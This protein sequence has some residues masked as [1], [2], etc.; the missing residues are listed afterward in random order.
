MVFYPRFFSIGRGCRQ[1]DP[2]SPY[3]FT[4]SVEIIAIMIR[5][6]KKIKGLRIDGLEIKLGQYADGTQIFLDGSEEALD[7][8][9]TVLEEFRSLSGLK[10]NM[11]KTKAVWIG[12]MI[13][14]NLRLCSK[15]NLDWVI[16]GSF[17]VLGI[18]MNADL[19]DIWEI[20]LTK[21]LNEIRSLLARWGRRRLSIK[22]RITVIKSLALS[23]L[24]YLFICLPNPPLHVLK[25]IN[26]L[27][28]KFIWQNKPDKIKRDTLQQP[29]I[30]G[31]LG[32]VNIEHFL[33]SLK[34]TWLRR[35]IRESLSWQFAFHQI[36]KNRPFI[37]TFGSNYLQTHIKSIDN[38]FWRDIL[39]AYISLVDKISI[40][41]FNEI[42][43]EPLWFNSHFNDGH[44]CIHD[45]AKQGILFIKDILT[46]EGTFFKFSDLKQRF[47]IKGT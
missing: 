43:N 19:S 30:R 3:L 31:G 23:K 38:P 32:M 10:I 39:A 14:S 21:K 13:N 36:I 29:F 33:K 41:C 5:N 20:N 34:L 25:D 17:N 12:S 15:Y 42:L 44:M 2:L 11:E 1:G 47:K 24:V 37:W 7:S 35:T 45:W 26:H 40:E 9:L 6:N 28:Y 22:G 16:S 4:L 18:N 27:F 8:T 46:E